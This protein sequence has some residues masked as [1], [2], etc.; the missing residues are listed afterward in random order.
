MQ[1]LQENT[2]LEILLNKVPGRKAWT[3]IFVW[4]L[5]TFKEHLFYRTPPLAASENNEQQ[6]LSEGFAD[7]CYKIV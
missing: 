1:I 6:Q 4:Y 7:S 3:D 2:V 5:Q